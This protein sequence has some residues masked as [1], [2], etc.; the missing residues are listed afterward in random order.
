MSQNQNQQDI[1]LRLSQALFESSED[2][3]A[4]WRL[5]TKLSV[6]YL[7]ADLI[8]VWIVIKDPKG[9]INHC[10]CEYD[11]VQS[12]YTRLEDADYDFPTAHY[13]VYMNALE[14]ERTLAIEDCRNDARSRELI[15]QFFIPA[16]TFSMLD[17]T[18]RSK[19]G[20]IGHISI[21]HNHER[22]Q[23]TENEIFFASALADQAS[24]A[25]LENQRTQMHNERVEQL[26]RIRVQQAAVA[27][28]YK[29]QTTT[30]GN[31]DE[32]AGMICRIIAE[33]LNSQI[34]TVYLYKKRDDRYT[35]LYSIDLTEQ[36][37]QG[38]QFAPSYKKEHH[39]IYINALEA[40]DILTCHDAANDPRQIEFQREIALLGTQSELSSTVRL[41][42]K[43]IGFICCEKT[44]HLHQ[45]TSD[46]VTFMGNMS[47]LF[48]HTLLNNELHKAKQEAE[49]ATRQKSAFLAN[50]S[51]E[52]R[53][54]MNGILGMTDIILDSKLSEQQ[55]S[56]IEIIRSSG[57]ALMSL[58]NDILDLS[59]IEAGELGIETRSFDLHRLIQEIKRLFLI[60]ANQKSLIFTVEI[61]QEVPQFIE[62]DPYRL[63]QIL[64]NLLANS[65]KFTQQGSINL[66]CKLAGMIDSSYLL[67]FDIVDTGIGFD[68]KTKDY[69]FE[70]FTQAD[71]ST[72]REYGGT[73]LGLNISK[74]LCHLLGGEIGAS[75]EL[76][77]GSTF[78]FTIVAKPGTAA[79]TAPA[80]S[81]D[82][83]P[84]TLESEK[85]RILV[86]EDNQVNQIVISAMLKK[87]G[88]DFDLVADGNEALKALQ[89]QDY[90]LIL[91]DCQMPGMD[92]FEATRRIRTF[93]GKKAKVKIVAL[94]ANAMNSDRKICLAAGMD[95]YISKPLK[96]IDLQRVIESAIDQN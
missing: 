95:D 15:E 22:H 75:S 80:D 81:N 30:E 86:A 19:H 55:R 82:K 83:L 12:S 46:E 35:S 84:E 18:I 41:R 6:D 70:D 71:T 76:G 39:P 33:V 4:F 74:M 23:W 42:G 26:Q 85:I 44:D 62:S 16:N 59:K 38:N 48:T 69:L 56:H 29:S 89:A 34:V 51:H 36:D 54:P 45:W 10:V 90:G 49:E 13:P 53:T 27:E 32:T 47:S 68:Q 8:S 2:L 92:G 17:A 37:A 31:L 7:D 60:N 79:D 63:R 64:L 72:A 78:W 24:I 52:I 1:L 61:S 3:D 77:A 43:M 9:D 65:V 20:Y 5:L 66:S 21:E 67:K 57:D 50:M 88:A 73:G 58:I 87:M 25:V 96:A 93:Q 40:E 91:M 94:T 28:L 11:R 14:T